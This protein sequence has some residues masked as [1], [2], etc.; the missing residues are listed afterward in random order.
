MGRVDIK[1]RPGRES[2]KEKRA[3]EAREAAAA[4]ASDP[5]SARRGEEDDESPD[6]GPMLGADAPSEPIAP[7]HDTPNT[8]PPVTPNVPQQAKLISPSLDAVETTAERERIQYEPPPEGA[9]DDEI[10]AHYER[11]IARAHTYVQ[12]VLS[13][14]NKTWIL[15]AGRSL[16]ELHDSGAWRKSGYSDWNKYVPARWKVSGRTARNWMDAVDVYAGLEDLLNVPLN[17]RQVLELGSTLKKGGVDAM[18]DQWLE[19]NRT[20]KTSAPSLRAVRDF[21]SLGATGV[22]EE[23]KKNPLPAITK[24]TRARK[25]FNSDLLRQAVED[26]PEAAKKLFKELREIL[27]EV[28]S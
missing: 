18:R 25:A 20:G 8:S 13:M 15:V 17:K 26:D 22:E 16:K 5:G 19:A 7:G 3:R 10:L 12:G 11:N 6:P 2:A 27:D 24:L 14:G 28:E 21:L 9:T 4:A 1:P 23:P